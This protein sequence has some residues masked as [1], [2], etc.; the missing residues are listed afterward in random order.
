MPSCGVVIVG[1]L[2]AGHRSSACRSQRCSLSGSYLCQS[3][4]G[5]AYPCLGVVAGCHHGIVFAGLFVRVALA[6]GLPLHGP[7][8]LFV[9]VVRVKIRVL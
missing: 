5:Q 7:G 6:K 1:V 8:C 2:F 3:Y 9:Y 4:S